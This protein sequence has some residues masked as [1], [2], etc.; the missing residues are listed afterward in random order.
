MDPQRKGERR[1]M[2]GLGP[3]GAP[4]PGMDLTIFPNW[5][6][7]TKQPENSHV[8]Y[9]HINELLVDFGGW[10]QS[11]LLEVAGTIQSELYCAVLV[12]LKLMGAI[13]IPRSLPAAYDSPNHT[14][15][16]A[17]MR[18][19]WACPSLAEY[20][21]S[22]PVVNLR[23]RIKSQGLPP[24]LRRFA[25]GSSDLETLPNQQDAADLRS[26]L[27]GK[28]RDQTQAAPVQAEE[29]NEAPAANAATEEA[30]IDAGRVAYKGTDTRF[31]NKQSDKKALLLFL[32]KYP[33]P[34]YEQVC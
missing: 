9:E 25:T 4:T 22:D 18:I 21:G 20:L 26:K 12:L 33:Q 11:L 10:D 19:R 7:P 3:R 23:G 13:N 31:K 29:I 16:Q 15:E 30:K 5:R 34:K 24:H 28:S 2:L 14:V 1:R 17:V 32:D 6:D 27:D 8:D